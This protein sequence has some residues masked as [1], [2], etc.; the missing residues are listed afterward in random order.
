MSAGAS[1][2]TAASGGL[3]VSIRLTPK[4]SRDQVRGVAVEA[5]G[6]AVLKVQVT[7]VPEDGKANA[8]L[9]KLLAKTWRLPRTTMDI[10]QGTTDRRKVVLISGDA[11]DLRQRLDLWMAEQP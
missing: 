7:A 4:S 9:V 2:F 1:P 8:A 3:R 5:D 11:E 6:H 10:V